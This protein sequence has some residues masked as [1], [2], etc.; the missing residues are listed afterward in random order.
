MVQPLPPGASDPD[1]PMWV[2]PGAYMEWQQEELVLRNEIA[3]LQHEIDL[4]QVEIAQEANETERMRIRAQIRQHGREMQQRTLEL[5]EQRRVTELGLATSPIDFVAYEMYKRYL[6]EQATTQPGLPG[7]VQPHVPAGRG[8][9]YKPG[10][11]PPRGE[12]IPLFAPEDWHGIPYG[13]V[14]GGGG[15]YMPGFSGPSAEARTDEDIQAM[16]AAMVGGGGGSLGTGAFGVDV[17]MTQALSRQEVQALSQGEMDIISSFLRAGFE[18]KGGQET[19]YDPLDYWREVQE[20]WVPYMRETG[21]TQYQ[22]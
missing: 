18:G 16:V 4:L 12:W 14:E 10:E 7:E 19:S 17:P 5:N 2:E 9:D 6:T 13:P 11:A 15:M 8:P 3:D 21:P 20:G 1:S 22:F